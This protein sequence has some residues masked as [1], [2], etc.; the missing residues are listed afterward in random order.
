MSCCLDTT[1]L[2]VPCKYRSG[3][4]EEEE[5]AWVKAAQKMKGRSSKAGGAAAAASAGEV[6]CR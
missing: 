6:R 5:D 4:V 3:E 2:P 1:Q